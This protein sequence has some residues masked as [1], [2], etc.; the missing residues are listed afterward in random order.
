LPGLAINSNPPNLSLPKWLGLQVWAISAWLQGTISECHLVTVNVW[1]APWLSQRTP[2]LT[3]TFLRLMISYSTCLSW[4][5]KE[6]RLPSEIT[7]ENI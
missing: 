4:D 2:S 7:L 5:M 3:S 1:S 6:N